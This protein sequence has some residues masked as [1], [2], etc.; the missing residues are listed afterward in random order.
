MAYDDISFDPCEPLRQG[1]MPL[2]DDGHDLSY[3]PACPS[4]PWETIAST[5]P[6]NYR[7]QLERLSTSLRARSSLLGVFLVMVFATGV[8]QVAQGVQNAAH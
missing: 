3:P 4:Q 6:R 5:M 8:E 7:E 1:V 2:V